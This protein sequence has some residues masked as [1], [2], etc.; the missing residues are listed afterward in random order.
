MMRYDA[1][2]AM[3]DALEEKVSIPFTDEFDLPR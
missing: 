2:I 3:E 1:R